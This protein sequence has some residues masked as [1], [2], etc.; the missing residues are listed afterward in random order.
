[1]KKERS[2]LLF[3]FEKILVCFHDEL[4][5]IELILEGGKAETQGDIDRLLI[6]DQRSPEEPALDTAGEDLGTGDAGIRKKECELVISDTE[7]VICRS[8][9]GA[10]D[11]CDVLKDDFTF[12]CAVIRTELRK[13]IDIHQYDGKTRTV[14]APSDTGEKA[15]IA[16]DHLFEIL[17]VIKPGILVD[18]GKDLDTGI[19]LVALF[20]LLHELLLGILFFGDIL[21]DAP[22]PADFAGVVDQGIDRGRKP[23]RLERGP[24]TGQ[25]QVLFQMKDRGFALHD[26]VFTGGMLLR[27]FL[28]DKCAEV[29]SDQFIG[30]LI[31]EKA[32]KRGGAEHIAVV[33][34][35]K[36]H[37][38]IDLIEENPE[39][40]LLR[41]ILE[42][43]L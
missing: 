25:L 43:I 7:D 18:R 22:G 10:E 32:G 34:I 33:F 24:R 37:R 26:A 2:A 16:L 5:G 11:V 29:F 19:Q 1:M 21:R 31:A 27:I 3:C 9:T 17:A 42:K 28:G 39:K 13:M 4:R 20:I 36:T 12:L 41:K 38:I 6:N 15:H 30:S 40:V 23:D 8:G 14:A 35:L